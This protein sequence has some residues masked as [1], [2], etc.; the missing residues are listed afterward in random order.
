MRRIPKAWQA[1][2]FAALLFS[3]A[4]AAT[5]ADDQASRMHRGM[6]ILDD[7]PMWRDPARARFQPRHFARLAQAGFDTVRLNLHPFKHLGAAGVPD[8]AW[9]ATLD[10]L[11]KAGLGAGLTVI[12]DEHDDTLCAR[13][14]GE[15]LK[16]LR[17]VWGTLAPRYRSAPDR[18]LFEILNEPHGALTA[19]VWN[20]T[21]RNLI[22]L[23]RATNPERN[24]VIGP[25]DMNTVS[26]L[27]S[28]DLPESD[29]HIIATVHY[30]TPIRFTLQGASWVPSAKDLFGVAW[31]SDAEVAAVVRDFDRVKVW[32]DTHRRPIF[33][34]EFGAYEKAPMDS[35]TRWIARVARVA[36]A[37][38][39]SWAYWQMDTDFAAYD[40]DRDAWIAP[41]LQALV[42]SN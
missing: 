37:H 40:F 30:Y 28:L 41:M 22:T 16:T 17:A 39:F 14:A 1:T 3:P 21:L 26:A 27:P 38:G 34:G 33:L 7:D 8:A 11:V 12:I 25:A 23:I 42:P 5:S 15:C 9:L 24:L 2:A 32:S 20:T 6:N 10:G 19:S 35:R 31:G 36:E 29:R 18:L 13:D 4:H